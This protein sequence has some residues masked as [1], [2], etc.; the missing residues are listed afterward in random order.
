MYMYMHCMHCTCTMYALVLLT[1]I[2]L[3]FVYSIDSLAQQ[4]NSLIVADFEVEAS[5]SNKN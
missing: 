2:P 4:V 5:L 1:W 3:R